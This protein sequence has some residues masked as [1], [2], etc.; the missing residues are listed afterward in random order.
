M[1]CLEAAPTNDDEFNMNVQKGSG[2]KYTPGLLFN[3]NPPISVAAPKPLSCDMY[4]R[5]VLPTKTPSFA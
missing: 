1:D 2:T 5:Y 3:V 4:S